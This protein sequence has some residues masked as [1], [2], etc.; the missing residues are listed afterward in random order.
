MP[1]DNRDRGALFRSDRKE[2][3]SDPDFSG[4]LDVEGRP[5]WINGWLKTSSLTVSQ[6]S[7]P[8]PSRATWAT[9]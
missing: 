7:T 6:I 1:Y 3:D 9:R 2:S 8:V 4:T 5:Y